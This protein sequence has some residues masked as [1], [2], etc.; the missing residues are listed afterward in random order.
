MRTI[1][2]THVERHIRSEIEYRSGHEVEVT[3]WQSR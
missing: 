1:D 2:L 3:S